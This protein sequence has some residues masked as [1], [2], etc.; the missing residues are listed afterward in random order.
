MSIISYQ[1]VKSDFPDVKMH[2]TEDLLE[3][4]VDLELTTAN[5][6]K[7]PYLGWVEMSIEWKGPSK[8]QI[9]LLYQY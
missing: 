5:G 6:R 1:D 8:C 2:T 9:E 4:G 3:S 7:L